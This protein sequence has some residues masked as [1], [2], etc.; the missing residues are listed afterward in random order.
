MPTRPGDSGGLGNGTTTRPSP[1]CNERIPEL[2]YGDPE[3]RNLHKHL[4]GLGKHSGAPMPEEIKAI[5]T[6]SPPETPL[7]PMWDKGGDSLDPDDRVVEFGVD[8][9]Q[10]FQGWSLVEHPLVEREGEACVNELP[11]VQSLCAEGRDTTNRFG[12]P[13][14]L[15]EAGSR[16]L[17]VKTCAC[18]LP[19]V[20]EST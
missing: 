5:A 3:A 6:C 2:P 8:G 4:H 17:C 11:V 13:R 20:P 7:L 14:T 15:P 16:R 19:S 18:Y 9:F 1:G 12:F 10:V